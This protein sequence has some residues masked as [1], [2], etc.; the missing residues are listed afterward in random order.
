MITPE[1][2]DEFN[3]IVLAAAKKLGFQ[4]VLYVVTEKV[5]DG[6][7]IEGTTIVAVATRKIDTDELISM[8]ASACEHVEENFLNPENA[9][10]MA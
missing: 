8:L 10:A 7:P 2:A 1:Q 5:D 3:E 9:E 6:S 4:S